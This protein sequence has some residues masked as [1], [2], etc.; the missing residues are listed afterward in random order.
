ME[1]QE[2]NLYFMPDSEQ[3]D[4]EG[5]IYGSSWAS[6]TYVLKMINRIEPRGARKFKVAFFS[7]AYDVHRHH[8][9]SGRPD[10]SAADCGAP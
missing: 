1:L 9:A 7:E 8:A 10:R 4:I 2:D 3:K 5:H 6:P